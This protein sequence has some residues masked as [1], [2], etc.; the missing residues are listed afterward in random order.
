MRPYPCC[1]TSTG[2]LTC[3][4]HKKGEPKKEENAK[5]G[6][7]MA[8][9][10]KQLKALIILFIVL[11]ILSIPC[12]ITYYYGTPSLAVNDSKTFFSMLTLGNLG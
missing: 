6:L 11:S 5:F 3:K 8:I 4:K 9:Y 1:S 10:F 12:F 2:W 7:G